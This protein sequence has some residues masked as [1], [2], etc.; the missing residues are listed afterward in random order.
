MELNIFFKSII[1]QDKCDVVICDLKHTIIYMN[2]AACVSYAK[3]GGDKLVGQSLLN[4]HNPHSCEMIERV[5]EWFAK[6]KDN[7]II[8]TFYNEKKNKDV[9]MVALR[10]E[11][12]ELIGYYEKHE[13]RNRDNS[14]LYDFN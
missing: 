11:D 3:R 5:V 1:D 6:S 10:N 12:G 8:H 2:P 7:N 9:Y 14:K 4:C 13:F